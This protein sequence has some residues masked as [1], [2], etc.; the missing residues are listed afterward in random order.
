MQWYSRYLVKVVA[1]VLGFLVALVIASQFLDFNDFL[2]IYRA[3]VPFGLLIVAFYFFA[4]STGRSVRL[5][6]GLVFLVL[7]PL[8][9]L[10]PTLVL[11]DGV[12]V[13]ASINFAPINQRFLREAMHAEIGSGI[14]ALGLIACGI[15]VINAVG[16]AKGVGARRLFAG[17]LLGLVWA[18]VVMWA[19]LHT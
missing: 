8:S 16:I 11:S 14:P 17:N 10:L 15:V 18:A 1:A 9:F 7:S 4:L 13:D 12:D 5:L 3:V 2:L 19:A 6:W